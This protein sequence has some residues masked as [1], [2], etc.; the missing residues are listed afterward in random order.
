MWRWEV[1]TGS[2]FRTLINRKILF[3]LI[4]M[5]TKIKRVNLNHGIN[6]GM[7]SQ[8]EYSHY[9]QGWLVLRVFVLETSMR[10]GARGGRARAGKV[11]CSAPDLMSRHQVT[12]QLGRQRWRT[13]GRIKSDDT[14]SWEEEYM[15]FLPHTRHNFEI[16]VRI[17]FIRGEILFFF[18]FTRE[19]PFPEFRRFRSSIRGPVTPA[20]TV[21]AQIW[22][23][24]LTIKQQC[25]FSLSGLFSCPRWWNWRVSA[26]FWLAWWRVRVQTSLCQSHSWCWWMSPSW[27]PSKLS[28]RSRG[29]MGARTHVIFEHITQ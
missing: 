7:W 6:S 28:W 13:R 21:P 4:N 24:S 22:K 15:V 12:L 25:L 19:H 3:I 8:C 23:L 2:Y 9:S 20:Q 26:G 27:E 18:F 5:K 14:Q 11:T 17:C 10:W 16:K 1:H 29:S